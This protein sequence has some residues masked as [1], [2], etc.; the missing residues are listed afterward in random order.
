VEKDGDTVLVKELLLSCGFEPE[1]A[2]SII[3][4]H[5]AARRYVVRY[6]DNNRRPDGENRTRLQ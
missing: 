5:H 1:D 4:G 2:V 6:T 3:A